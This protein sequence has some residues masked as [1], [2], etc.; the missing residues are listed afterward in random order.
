MLEGE[1]LLLAERISTTLCRLASCGWEE[2]EP[3]LPG[4]WG[5]LETRYD[6]S[7]PFQLM[8]VVRS[9]LPFRVASLVMEARRSSSCCK[10]LSTLSAILAA[11]LRGDQLRE[12]SRTSL[13]GSVLVG[14]S[15][16]M[17]LIPLLAASARFERSRSLKDLVK[18]VSI[19]AREAGRPC[20]VDR[21]LRAER[22][23]LE[24]RMRF[25]GILLA[26]A[27]PASLALSI[28]VD[29]LVLIAGAAGIVGLWWLI[30]RDGERFRALNIEVA[31]S[32]CKLG[33]RELAEIVGGLSAADVALAYLILGYGKS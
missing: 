29:P 17:G 24:R 30:R 12:A 32:E 28:V 21:L 15:G 3:R 23:R 6:P 20:S 4:W 13:E 8:K 5:E 25:Y 31:W 7:D 16:V 9:S 27:I 10:P 11:S 2:P 18:L 14:G 33:D 22:D 26:L 1:R 19:A